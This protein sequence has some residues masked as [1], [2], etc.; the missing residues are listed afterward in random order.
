MEP[1][2]GEALPPPRTGSKN[3]PDVTRVTQ[4]TFAI[5]PFEA[6]SEVRSIVRRN[7]G[8]GNRRS[9]ATIPPF[10][11]PPHREGTA[12]TPDV[13]PP[14]SDLDHSL[15]LDFRRANS[16]EGIHSRK[17]DTFP[18]GQRFGSRASGERTPQAAGHSKQ[19]VRQLARG[20]HLVQKVADISNRARWKTACRNPRPGSLWIDFGDLRDRPA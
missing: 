4:S 2:Q 1:L 6:P 14:K 15:P 7:A 18:C 17:A 5:P 11:G 12:R 20:T 13:T 19:S 16:V 9:C 3:R 10:F 8:W